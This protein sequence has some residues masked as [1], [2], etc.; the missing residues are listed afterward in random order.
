MLEFLKEDIRD[1]EAAIRQDRREL[2]MRAESGFD[3]EN[4]YAYIW[5]ALEE[6]Q[7]QPRKCGRCGIIATL[8]KPGKTFL[9]RADMDAL[10]IREESGLPFASQT[11]CMHACGH[12][13]HSAMLLG[14]ARL[15]KRH[16]G[17]LNG[18]IKLMFQ[19]AEELLMGAQDMI[20]GGALENP[21]VDAA[22]MLHVMTAQ[23]IPTGT[24]IISAPGVSAPAAG[25]FTLRIQGKGAHG[26]SPS[27]GIDPINAAAHTI[28]ALQAIN[29]RELPMSE[30]AAITI[31]M[32]QAGSA[33]NAIPDSALL[34]G[35]FRS[36]SD[37]TDAWIRRRIA[38]IS[39][40]TA[41]TFRAEADLH[42]DSGCPSLI[43]DE[44]LCAFA[45]TQAEALLGKDR[46]FN[47]A[48]LAASS[49]AKS[50][51]SEDFAAVSHCVPSV[52]IALAAGRP[53]DGHVHPLHHP[54]AT[55]D[56]AALPF[57]ALLYAGVAA[58]WLQA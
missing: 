33:A 37:E 22:M 8:G 55:F 39:R 11:G 10:P 21:H 25:T 17:E 48:K 19:P 54:K 34:R 40:G 45:Q 35:S 2:H 4:T 58:Q 32:L 41:A 50:S 42:F 44:N 18:C 46:V 13:M 5:Q 23:N 38:E 47:A 56:E 36:Y 6:M 15:L 24:A 12:D 20:D 14:A 1:L 31:G 7:L 28:L 27:A 43:N 49:A 57:G 52:M 26:A 3:L 53:Q 16:E 30:A 51:G 29:A 9:L